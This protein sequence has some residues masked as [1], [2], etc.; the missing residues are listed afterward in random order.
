MR[1]PRLAFENQL[2][3]LEDTLLNMGKEAAAKDFRRIFTCLSI[4]AQ[5]LQDSLDGFVSRDL[6]LVE[7]MT[8]SDD[9]VDHL[10]RSL[11]DEFW[12][13]MK[14]DPNLVEQAVQLLLISRYLE[15]IADHITNIGERVFYVETG[16][17]R[18]LHQ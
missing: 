9:E 10:Y 14:K 5:T 2:R 13:F 6:K 1:N 4:A 18:E 15:R 11:Y 12:E 16:K 7:K 3:E 8:S 17:L